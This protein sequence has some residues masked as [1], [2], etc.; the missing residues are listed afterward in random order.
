MWRVSRRGS[1]DGYVL[2][3][4]SGRGGRSSFACAG[5]G[6]MVLCAGR[7]GAVVFLTA[8]YALVD[9]AGLKRG[10]RLLV[11]AADGWGWYGGGAAG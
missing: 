8:Y 9:L 3:V 11:H 2:R 7:V 5:A 1:G 4:R 10:E 6:G